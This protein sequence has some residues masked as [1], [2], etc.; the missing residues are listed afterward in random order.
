MAGIKFDIIG[1][2]SSFK[3]AINEAASGVNEAKKRIENDGRGMGAVFDGLKSKIGGVFTAVAAG[4]LVGQIA[5]V[6]GE[7]QQLEVAFTTML[8]SAEKSRALMM[9]ATQTAATTPFGLQEVAGGFKQLL[10]YGLEMEKVNDTIVRLGDIAAGLSIPLGDLVNLYGTTMTQGRL[11]T[12]DM[13]QFMGRGIPIVDELAKQFGVTKD[14]VAELVTAGKVGFPE[15]EK[16]IIAMTSNGGKFGGLME[17]QSKTIVGQLSNIEDAIDGMFNEIG[18]SSEGMINLA[19]SGVSTLIENYDTIGTAL[20]VIAGAYGIN[21][22]A[23]ALHAATANAMARQEI[24]AY[25]AL[26]PLKEADNATDAKKVSVAKGISVA[27]AEELIAIRAKAQAQVKVLQLTAANAL[28]KKKAAQESLASATAEI[29]SVEAKMAVAR[30]QLVSTHA[31]NNAEYKNMQM[32]RLKNL[33]EERAMLIKAR[34]TAS[35]AVETTTLEA[36]TAVQAANTAQTNLNSVAN[37]VNARSVNVLSVAYGGLKKAI[38]SVSAFMAANPYLLLGAAIMTA[39]VGIYKMAT[40]LNAQEIAARAAA[41]AMAELR[42]EQEELSNNAKGYIR[43]IQDE[44]ASAI[45]R[46]KAYQNLKEALPELTSN[47]SYMQIMAMSS[48]EAQKM[49]NDEIERT[50]LL[51]AKQ[52]VE[53]RQGQGFWGQLGSYWNENSF[54]EMSARN[55][56]NMDWKA[57]IPIIGGFSSFANAAEKHREEMEDALKKE[58]EKMQADLEE[59]EWLALPLEVKITQTQENKKRIED[60]MKTIQEEIERTKVAN[61]PAWQKREITMSLKLKFNALQVEWGNEDKRLKDATG[62]VGQETNKQARQR[63]QK[64]LS[65]KRAELK[66]ITADNAL[67]DKTTADALKTE[68]SNLEKELGIS[69]KSTNERAQA[70]KRNADELLKLTADN[71]KARIDLMEDGKDKRLAIIDQEYEA[72]VAKI[73]K[74]AKKFADDNK[75]AGTKG[76]NQNGLTSDQQA[77]I[78]LAKQ[79][80]LQEKNKATVEMYKD[81]ARA[82]RDYLKEYGSFYQQQLAITEEYEERIAKAKSDGEKMSLQKERDKKL[83]ETKYKSIVGDIDWKALFSGVSSLS[84]EMLKPMLGQLNAYTQTD[85]FKSAGTQT[86]QDVVNLIKELKGFV[87]GQDVTFEQLANATTAFQNA[88][89]EYN[90]L[91]GLEAQAYSNLQTAKA[92]Y[93]NGEIDADALNHAQQIFDGYAKSTVE[94]QSEVNRLGVAL[95]SATDE[96]IN[97]TSG[98]T[99]ALNKAQTWAGVEGFGGVKNAVGNVDALKGVLT[100]A[101]AGLSADNAGGKNSTAIELGKTIETGLTKGLNGVNGAISGALSSGMGQ[102]VGIVAQ[103]PNLILGL[104]DGIKNMAVGVLDGFTELISLRWIDDLVVSILD[105]VGN[106]INA[107]FDLPENLFKVIS[108]I[109]VDGI[110]GLLNTVIGRIGNV[111][112][113]GLLSSEGPASWFTNSNAKEVQK[114]IDRLTDRNE[115]LQ[116]AIEDLTD[117]I[118]SGQGMQSVKDYEKAIEL[119]AELEKNTLKKAKA[120]ASYHNSH[121]SWNYYWGGFAPEDIAYM[122]EVMGRQWDGSLWSLSP[123]EMKMLRENVALWEKI[124]DTGEGNYGGRLIEYLNAYADLAGEMDELKDTL[125]EGLTQISFDSLYDN[126]VNTLMNMEASA[127]DFSEDLSEMFMRAMLTNLIGEQYRDKLKRWYENF[128]E[129]MKN[130]AALDEGELAS[131]RA[132]YQSITEDA[133]KERDA[134][135]EVVGYTGDG[136]GSSAEGSNRTVTSMSQETANE[137]TGRFTAMQIAMESMHNQSAVQTSI[138]QGLMQSVSPLILISTGSNRSLS[139]IRNLAIQRNDYLADIAKFT[140]HLISIKDNIALVQKQTAN[141]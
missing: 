98:L 115:L 92:R 132:D 94:A 129:A 68:I 90:A 134:I 28:A 49:L 40:A 26:L 18:Q 123:D 34:K 64:E 50:T 107:I 82:M 44:T 63:L 10:A 131:L 126:F 67:Y 36:N 133:I 85:E 11:F 21:K 16:A 89:S 128:A 111:L 136:S 27:R 22:A 102:M 77:E 75:K 37:T 69:K 1:D 24:A 137:L 108:S 61:I 9:Q 12:Q 86:Q 30:Q 52:A 31:L 78:D 140:K 65:E 104:A 100:N 58:Y 33:E 124:Q 99:Q 39:V 7:F 38:A 110:G 88:V 76:L 71:E 95:N 121:H 8:G 53:E 116:T 118:E 114:T 66:R 4:Q 122:S 48:A 112:T 59:A 106:L 83:G 45:D 139:E 14:K 74:L 55:L 73:D 32:S 101:L 35:I 91:Q 17:A 135:A 25:S 51:K 54:W 15:V 130:D 96:V 23:I 56:E 119:Q 13:R 87:G 103:L 120:Q 60:E 117:R 62:G 109:V 5:K 47:M 41:E 6:R 97:F 141:L 81:E 20:A 79:Y 105:A 57:L 2:S 43:T 125:N 113:F 93:D 84:A 46:A 70:E 138:M 72:E 3:Q 19:L 80:A 127:E 42:Q 29:A